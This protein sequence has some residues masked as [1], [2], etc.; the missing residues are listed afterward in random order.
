MSEAQR[1]RGRSDSLPLQ[2]RRISYKSIPEIINEDE[3]L[4]QLFSRVHILSSTP[5]MPN[6]IKILFRS[7][8]AHGVVENM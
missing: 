8:Q 6:V 4:D 3:P 1:V 5:D 2:S 7:E